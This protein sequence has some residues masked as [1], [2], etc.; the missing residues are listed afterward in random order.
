MT[1]PKL[2][3]AAARFGRQLAYC[4]TA[5]FLATLVV[6]RKYL[7][8]VPDYVAS[9]ATLSALHESGNSAQ[10]GI[11]ALLVA[12]PLVVPSSGLPLHVR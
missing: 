1:D 5:L 12:I 6:Q 4:S 11:A 9:S 10:L 3:E 2:T 8:R 7:H